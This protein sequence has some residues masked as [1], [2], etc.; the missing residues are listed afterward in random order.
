SAATRTP[1]ELAVHFKIAP[2]YYMYR[3]RFGFAAEP[4][5]AAQALGAPVFPRGLVKYDPTFEKD[6]EGYY[7]QVTITL[8]LQAGAASQPFPLAVTSQGWA[9]AGLCYP[10]MT[11]ELALAPVDGGY[12]VS[13]KGVVQSVPE[14]QDYQAGD[15]GK[16]AAS[17]S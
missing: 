13:G 5:A 12:R 16:P 8:P 9:D 4:E 11:T 7:G 10:P 1:T 6:L 17:S 3:E 15:G 14:P 2:D